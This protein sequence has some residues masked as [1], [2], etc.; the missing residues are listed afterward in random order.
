MSGF[1]DRHGVFV[2]VV[3]VIFFAF[4]FTWNYPIVDDVGNYVELSKSI[5]ENGSYSLDGEPHVKRLPVFPLISAAMVYLGFDYL[6][7]V[8]VAALLLG[9]GSFLFYYMIIKNFISKVGRIR[10]GFVDINLGILM[11]FSPLLVLYSFFVGIAESCVIFFMLGSLYFFL[12]AV[13]GKNNMYYLCGLFSVLAGLS[14][15]V[16]AVIIVAYLFYLVIGRIGIKKE[17]IISFFAVFLTQLCWSIRSYSISSDITGGYAGNIGT[18]LLFKLPLHFSGLIVVLVILSGIFYIPLLFN[19]WKLRN[20]DFNRMNLLLV[21]VIF[22]ILAVSAFGNFKWRYVVPAIPFLMLL[23]YHNFSIRRVRVFKYLV[24]FGII[25]NLLITPYFVNG[26]VKNFADSIYETPP[27]WSQQGYDLMKCIDWVNSNAPEGSYVSSRGTDV[28]AGY[29]EGYEYLE[30]QEVYDQRPDIIYVIY[31][32]RT[33]TSF[34]KR[35][36]KNGVVDSY[37]IVLDEEHLLMVEDS[38]FYLPT[39]L[40]DFDKRFVASINKVVLLVDDVETFYGFMN[41]TYGFEMVFVAPGGKAWVYIY[42]EVVN[43][44]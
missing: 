20:K 24:V 40:E 34:S 6:H 32:Y 31:D 25:V 30:Y 7:S 14:R 12:L 13:N 28:W 42:R 41:D 4:M 2:I 19:A 22:G 23:Y 44:V 37:R 17:F 8:R 26:T 10:K 16:G 43:G 36:I 9:L 5:Y 38:S 3:A 33:D 11:Y 39:Q 1:F 18:N 21:L 15:Q 29:F 35:L 27:R